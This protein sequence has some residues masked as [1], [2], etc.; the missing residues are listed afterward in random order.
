M[1]IVNYVEVDG[2]ILRMEELSDGK[3]KEMEEK[4]ADRIMEAANFERG[5]M[6]DIYSYLDDIRQ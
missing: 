4:L 1:K 2:Q 5:K 6:G 3:R